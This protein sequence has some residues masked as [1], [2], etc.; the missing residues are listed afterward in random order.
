MTPMRLWTWTRARAVFANGVLLIGSVALSLLVG[1]AALR[2][3]YAGDVHDHRLLTTYHPVLG[4]MKIPNKT[5]IHSAPEY[6]VTETMNSEGIRGPE[7]SRVKP[8]GERRILILGDSFAEGYTVEFDELFSEVLKHRLNARVNGKGY[9]Y[10]VINTGTGGYSTD[11]ELLLFQTLGKTYH[12]DITILM[13]VDNDV[14]Y[15]NSASYPRG[16]KPLFRLEDGVLR[17]TNVP[18]PRST[19]ERPSSPG[20]SPSAGGVKAWLGEHSRFYAMAAEQARRNTMLRELAVNLRLMTPQWEQGVEPVPEEF[21]VLKQVYDPSIVEAWVITEA[22]LRLLRDEVAAAGAQLVI[23]YVPGNYRVDP[24]VWAMASK[25]YGFSEEGWSAMR[26]ERELGGIC[27]RLGIRLIDPSDRFVAEAK[28]LAAQGDHLFF[29]MDGHW[30]RNG[31]RLAGEV[32]TDY[33]S[34]N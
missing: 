29:P 24:E 23:Y 14:F 6:R 3:F 7:Y 4:W 15:N 20:T 31:H 26:A 17:L 9:H 16:N 10:E 34:A 13:F 18:V 22:L 33:L 30:N 27:A 5:G 21:G 11:Q 19:V 8:P 25:R 12:P 32:L 28:R 1:E 2:V